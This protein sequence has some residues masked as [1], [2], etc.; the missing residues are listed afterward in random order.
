[1]VNKIMDLEE[2]PLEDRFDFQEVYIQVLQERI[3]ELELDDIG[4]IPIDN[5][6]Q[7]DFSRE[8]LQRIINRSRLFFLSHP[9]INRAVTL[10]SFYV[11]GQG[12]TINATDK[13][14]QKLIDAW[15][16]NQKNRV[17]FTSHQALTMKEQALQVEGNIF[18]V[19][20]PDEAND[21]F[22][23]R[24]I[25]TEEIAEII[26]NPNDRKEVWYYKR[27]YTVK[28]LNMLTGNVDIAEAKRTVYYADWKYAGPI[29][30]SIGGHQVLP[31]RVYH[32]R[33]GGLPDQVYGVPETYQALDWAKAYR[34]FLED[35]STI[36][37]SY[38]RF[39]WAGKVSGGTN[40]VDALR[41]KLASTLTTRTVERN[42]ASSTGSAFV[43]NEGASLQP[44]KTAG[45]TT[46]AEEG[47]RLLLMVCAAVGLPET[48]MG[49]VSVGTLATAKSLDRPTELKFQDRQTLWGDVIK[50]FITYL[51]DVTGVPEGEQRDVSVTFPS[52]LEHD[53]DAQITAIVKGSTLDG[54]QL[55]DVM[56]PR[57]VSE[58][59]LTALGV[60]NVN[61]IIDEMNF[62]DFD[63]QDE[64]EDEE[65]PTV[66][67]VPAP[68]T[69]EQAQERFI[70]SVRNLYHTLAADEINNVATDS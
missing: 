3:A 20:F 57:K 37:R 18:F 10:Q 1:M 58:L 27:S 36:Q 55:A 5:T 68:L 2:M 65:V 49:D 33:V 30:A 35:W 32:V 14:T 48:F 7:H 59:I 12:V 66:P 67:V 19:L 61:E 24:S 47:R 42:P 53:V 17:E 6:A 4:W 22:Y 38:A 44:I 25:P 26:T 8:G 46:G 50:D 43:A 21:T 56:P 51:F 54:K 29:P 34:Q 60:S 15:W 45:A 63:L 40:Q 16:D 31:A 41:D 23:I 11:W 28:T 39:A 70:E 64:D 9:L 52:I 13:N 62:P 69:P